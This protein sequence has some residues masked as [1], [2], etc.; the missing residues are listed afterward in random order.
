LKCNDEA[1]EKL[2][3]Y[4]IDGGCT[5]FCPSEAGLHDINNGRCMGMPINP[6]FCNE[7]EEKI[8]GKACLK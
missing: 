3:K 8:F 1:V 4:I 7:C 2:I 6:E 5:D